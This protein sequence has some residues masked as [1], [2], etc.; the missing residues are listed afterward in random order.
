MQTL[1]QYSN[2]EYRPH[3]LRTLTVH[4][5]NVPKSARKTRGSRS[6]PES[7]FLNPSWSRLE[8]YLKLWHE[9]VIDLKY[10]CLPR[11]IVMAIR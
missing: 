9:V 1:N 2:L 7:D 5:S 4:A 3:K 8:L 6:L 10:Q 11:M